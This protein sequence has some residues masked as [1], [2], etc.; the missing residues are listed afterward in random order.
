MLYQAALDKGATIR[1]GCQVVSVDE[2]T[3]SVTLKSGEVVHGDV[4]IGADGML[5]T[6]S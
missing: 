6:P 1:L 2:Q 3:P 5:P 4:I